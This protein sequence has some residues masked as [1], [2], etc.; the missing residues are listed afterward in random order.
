MCQSDSVNGSVE[1]SEA[2]WE[3]EEGR[4]GDAGMPE[5]DSVVPTSKAVFGGF[6]EA[7]NSNSPSLKK[8][9]IAAE[10]LIVKPLCT[11]R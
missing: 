7:V 9:I 2:A 11:V 3:M 1:A 4:D 8:D 5:A 6:T 10:I